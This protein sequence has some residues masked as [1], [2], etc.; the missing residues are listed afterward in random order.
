[1]RLAAITMLVLAAGAAAG[2]PPRGL[3]DLVEGLESPRLAGIEV[4]GELGDYS[5][6][7]LHLAAA[8]RAYPVVVGARRVGYFLLGGRFELATDDRLAAATFALNLK[9]ASR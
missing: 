4:S 7:S 5:V 6:G 9:R 1:M 8:G 2:E 3:S